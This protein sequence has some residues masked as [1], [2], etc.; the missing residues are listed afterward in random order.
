MTAERVIL[1]RH[2]QTDWNVQRR[3]QGAVDFP[4]NETGRRQAA[5]AA[6]SVARME[7]SRIVS[8]PLSRAHDTAR[9]VARIIGVTVDVDARLEERNYGEWEG[10]TREE[11]MERDPEEFRIW[12]AGRNPEGL[13]IEASAVLGERVAA[14]VSD[15]AESMQGGTL[16][17]ASHGAAIRAG[18]AVLLGLDPEAWSGIRGMDNCHW[19]V[20]LP[21][22]NRKPSWRLVNYNVAC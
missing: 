9:E 21:Q 17:V 2:G 14:A 3:I 13:G 11:I 20:L 16:L 12:E 10:L 18:L 19:A 1:W 6:Q 5:E 15:H 4:L 7:P 22:P 8:S